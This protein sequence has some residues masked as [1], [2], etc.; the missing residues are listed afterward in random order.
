[1][2]NCV[3]GGVCEC[4]HVSIAFIKFP[5]GAYDPQNISNNQGWLHK[6]TT[7]AA[8]D[9]STFRRDLYLV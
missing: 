1:M 8:A 5:K 6:Y 9:G 7:C 2:Q 3:C 4:M